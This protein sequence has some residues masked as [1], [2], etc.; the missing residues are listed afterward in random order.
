MTRHPNH[1]LASSGCPDC[2]G[3]DDAPTFETRCVCADDTV[4]DY[5]EGPLI[6][7]ECRACEEVELV[8][9]GRAA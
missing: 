5:C 9:L 4:C 7:G 6:G 8:E 2:G 3:D 1:P